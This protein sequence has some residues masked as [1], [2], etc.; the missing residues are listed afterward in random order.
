MF[1]NGTGSN[2]FGQVAKARTCPN[3]IARTPLF[4]VEEGSPSDKTLVR[5]SSRPCGPLKALRPA[6]FQAQR[7]IFPIRKCA[8]PRYTLQRTVGAP[9]THTEPR[10]I[11][12]RK[13]RSVPATRKGFGGRW[14]ASVRF[15]KTWLALLQRTC[16]FPLA[17][18]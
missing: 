8:L 14:D 10:A 4:L 1:C 13:L 17:T 16:I 12:P 18:S 9:Q 15:W 3:S 5:N 2:L 11:T 7:G 6:E